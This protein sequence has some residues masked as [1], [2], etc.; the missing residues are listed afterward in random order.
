MTARFRSLAPAA[1]FVLIVAGCGSDPTTTPATLAQSGTGAPSTIP[2][3]T[4]AATTTTTTTTTNAATTPNTTTTTTK[5][6][7]TTI[8][9]TTMPPTSAVTVVPAGWSAVDRESLSSKAFPPCCGD[10]WHGHVSPVLPPVGQPLADG[11]YAVAMQ[12]P[13]DPSQP[14]ELE[15]FRFEQCALLPQQSCESPAEEAG[16]GPDELGVDASASRPLTVALD[17]HVRVVVVGWDDNSLESDGFIVE[18]ANGTNF[19]ELT[20]EVNQAYAAV[21]ADRFLA[22]E[23]PNAIIADVLADP[24]GGFA[25][26][27]NENHGFIFTPESG[28]PLLFQVIFP[29]VDGQRVAWRGTEPPAIRS[30]DIAD[31]QVTVYVY[32]AYVP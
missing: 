21:F 1:L 19:A 10:T 11:P 9:A 3:S 25:P 29:Y 22:G 20:M 5:T 24:T 18:Q 30:I 16:Y 27:A 14:L 32:A 31:E 4:T 15:V 28:P 12:W 7:T 8:A 2:E 13:D 26:A 6:T 23:D 17:E